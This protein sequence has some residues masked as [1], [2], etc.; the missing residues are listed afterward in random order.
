VKKFELHL[1]VVEGL[2]VSYFG[3]WFQEKWPLE[4]LSLVP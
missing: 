2:F 3:Y 1:L 4:I